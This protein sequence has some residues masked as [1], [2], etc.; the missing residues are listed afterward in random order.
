MAAAAAAAPAAVADVEACGACVEM[1]VQGHAAL[2]R[3][4]LVREQQQQG[5]W[6]EGKQS[7]R[8]VAAEMAAWKG[9]CAY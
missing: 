4:L 1:A 8:R 3:R 5:G 2:L 7:G 6:K 9:A